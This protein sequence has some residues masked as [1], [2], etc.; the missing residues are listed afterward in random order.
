M[1]CLNPISPTW[2]TCG[3]GAGPAACPGIRV[4]GHAECLLHLDQGR[5]ATHLATLT[6][7]ADLDHRGTPFTEVLLGELLDALRDPATGTARTGAARFDAANF[8]GPARFDGVH[9][10]GEACF[11]GA[12]FAGRSSFKGAAFDDSADFENARFGLAAEFSG[13]RFIGTAGF[14]DVRFVGDARFLKTRF[15]E[16]ARFTNVRFVCD[17]WFDEAGFDGNARFDEAEFGGY[18]H[19]VRAHFGHDAGFSGAV[20]AQDAHFFQAEFVREAGFGGTRFTGDAWFREAR[21][22]GALTGP[23]VCAG[24]VNLSGAIFG[25]PLTLQVAARDL[26]CVRVR[27]ESTATLR[28]RYAR[29]DLTDAVVSAPLAVTAHSSPFPSPLGQEV[30]EALLASFPAGVSI[31]SVQGV[32]AAHLMLTDTDLSDCLFTGAF[33]LDQIRLEGRTAFAPVPQGVQRSPHARLIRW[34][35]RRTVAE[36]HHWRAQTSGQTSSVPGLPTPAGNW[37]TGPHHGDPART[38]QPEAVAAVYRQLRKAF[39][40]GKNEPGAADFYYGEM[41]MRRHDRAATPRAERG[42][43]HGYW[44][45]SGYGLR[46]SRAVAWLVAAMLATVVLMMAVGLPTASPKQKATG[47]VP[48]GGGRVTLEIDKEDPV[49]P[50]GQRYTGKRFEKAL[51]VTLNSVVFRS[52]GQ[53]LTTAGTY[54]EMTS[55]LLEP[56]LLALA[57]LAVRGRVKR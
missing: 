15:A 36:E 26:V 43:L 16:S 22:S 48:T 25:V 35:R 13:A 7:G 45:L 21:F 5:R 23:V 38:P 8:T 55:R 33:H 30:D 53:G 9:F 6:P 54:V 49:N 12:R 34:S 3:S 19:F 24:R 50:S 14:D 10:G 27:W 1:R 56:A 41:E 57:V 47:T 46:A 11:G 37:R 39:E 51:Q 17:A 44:L 42:L 4:S 40:D 18:A 20:F 2:V 52:S 29:V 28:V 32:D 31:N